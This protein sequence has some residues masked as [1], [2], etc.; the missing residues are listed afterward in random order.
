MSG[1]QSLISVGAIII[2][3]TRK[4]GDPCR[5]HACLGVIWE[6]PP[7]PTPGGAVIEQHTIVKALLTKL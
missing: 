7:L 6:Q 1:A 3:W 4:I 5:L 2:M